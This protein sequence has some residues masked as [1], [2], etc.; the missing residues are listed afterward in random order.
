MR[1]DDGRAMERNTLPRS[2]TTSRRGRPLAAPGSLPGRRAALVVAL[3]TLFIG[4]VT[5]T[6]SQPQGHYAA[7]APALRPP[8]WLQ[9]V[10]AYRRLASLP[11]VRENTAWRDGLLKHAR[12]MV[13]NDLIAHAE[14]PANRWFTPEG[15]QAARSSILM[16]HGDVT[17]SDLFAIDFW[18]QG[19]FHG[20]RIIDPAL[21][22]VEFA[23]YREADGGFQMA[24]A[25]DVIR[26]LGPIPP[27]VTF[28]L[29]WPSGRTPVPLRSY[30]GGETP[31]PLSACPGY[32]SPSGLP[33][34]L[35]LGPGDLTPGVTGH[36]LRQ[37]RRAVEHCVYDETS[38]RNP[39]PALQQLGRDVL[40][41]S[42]A[43]VLVPREPLIPGARYR[44]SITADGRT[45]VWS[46]RVGN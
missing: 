41:A 21:G 8:P 35:Q 23:A 7:A 46:F 12:Y 2:A 42:D 27:A 25:L 9:R 11:P 28:P 43:I 20:I 16:Y 26:G 17:T 19:P 6:P 31:D 32:T 30:T 45:H 4:L 33:L 10:N 29:A 3:L 38:Y 24:A 44:V 40:D 22:Q 39:D 14:D 1:H 36:S 37:G 15:D 34:I 5:A 18:M 13:K